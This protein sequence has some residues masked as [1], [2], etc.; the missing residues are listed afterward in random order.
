MERAQD[1]S[2]KLWWLPDSEAVSAG[3]LLRYTEMYLF[4]RGTAPFRKDRVTVVLFEVRANHY[5]QYP[6]DIIHP[7]LVPLQ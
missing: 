1:E 6:G 5:R 7:R 2:S 3:T 4:E